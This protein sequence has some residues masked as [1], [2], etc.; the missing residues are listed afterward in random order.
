MLIELILVMGLP[1]DQTYSMSWQLG[2]A[3]ALMV[4]DAVSAVA[5]ESAG[6]TLL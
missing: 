1:A 4:R 2:L 5:R 3:S 6:A